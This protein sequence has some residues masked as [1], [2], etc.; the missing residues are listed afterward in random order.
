M[1][2]FKVLFLLTPFLLLLMACPI[3]LDYPAEIMGKNPID[4]NL[5]GSWVTEAVG[6]ELK[7]VK[8]ED[9]GNNTYKVTVLERGE[10]YSLETDNLTGWVTTI[11]KLNILILQPEGEQKYYHYVYSY[12]VDN[13]LLLADVS[14]LVGGT[15][16]VTST[17]A[18][19]AEILES[20]E[21]E[22]FA[23]EKNTFIKVD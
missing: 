12:D 8:L 16:V 22:D 20:S 1:K 10:M 9:G 6:H 11:G 18:L 23:K 17:D 7:S 15:D 5:I 14:L 19:R 13:N 3:G 4:K 2:N 21:K